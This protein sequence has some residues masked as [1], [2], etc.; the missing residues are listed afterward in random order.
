MT[1]HRCPKCEG[2]MAEGFIV[3]ATHGGNVVSRW[4]EGQPERVFFGGLKIRGK[5]VHHVQTWRCQR[6]GYL[7]S[8]AAG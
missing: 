4:V 3:D 2:L 5:T 6:C 1:P 7:E 8:Y